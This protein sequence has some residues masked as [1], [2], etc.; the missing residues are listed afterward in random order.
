MNTHQI[1]STAIAA[2]VLLTAVLAACAGPGTSAPEYPETPETHASFAPV[3]FDAPELPPYPPN[4]VIDAEKS[5]ELRLRNE[6]ATWE[7]AVLQRYPD[8]QRPA[9]PFDE[10]VEVD[11]QRDLVL[12]CYVD[13]GVPHQVSLDG[14]GIE[15]T[16]VTEE[17][18][19][20]AFV[21]DSRFTPVPS[22]DFTPE[23]MGWFYDYWVSSYIPCREANGFTITEESGPTPT[24]EEYTAQ[25][26]ANQ[27]DFT[28]QVWYPYFDDW[29]LTEW[30]RRVLDEACPYDPR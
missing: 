5:E 2:A 12:D 4:V 14:E 6:D 18:V 28:T 21:C 9:V 10:Y 3:D 25:R 27:A 13:S 26:L 20:A 23:Q 16:M 8:A 19:I 30:D 15:K 17:Q 1:R 22:D 11:E 24:R 7:W 29:A